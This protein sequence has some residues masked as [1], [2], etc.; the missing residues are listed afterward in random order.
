[1]ARDGC[2]QRGVPRCMPRPVAKCT[3][4]IHVSRTTRTR[5]TLVRHVCDTCDTCA[6]LEVCHTWTVRVPDSYHTFAM[7]SRPQLLVKFRPK[8]SDGRCAATDGDT[9]TVLG[10]VHILH[11]SQVKWP[12]PELNHEGFHQSHL[13][14]VGLHCRP[15]I[16]GS[17]D[18]SQGASDFEMG[19]WASQGLAYGVHHHYDDEYP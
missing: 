16:R 2:D 8:L 17:W 6:T 1:M 12:S 11:F 4:Q 5:V 15:G 3:R 13:F 19:V 14:T 9:N 10:A 7:H 18:C